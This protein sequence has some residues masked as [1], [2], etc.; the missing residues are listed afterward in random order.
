MYVRVCMYTRVYS[1]KSSPVSGSARIKRLLLF[2]LSETA[3]EI[4]ARVCVCVLRSKTLGIST[5]SRLVRT[6]FRCCHVV[7]ARFLRANFKQSHVASRRSTRP[8]RAEFNRK[9]ASLIASRHVLSAT[10]SRTGLSQ[11]G[12]PYLHG[13]F[14]LR[15]SVTN[16][17][18]RPGEHEIQTRNSPLSVFHFSPDS[19]FESLTKLSNNKL[20][21]YLQLVSIEY[22][23]L[24]AEDEIERKAK[25]IFHLLKYHTEDE[26]GR[27][28]KRIF[29]QFKFNA[30]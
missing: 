23:F 9:M 16:K 11:V 18:P 20:K 7:E 26:I 27:K 1:R 6:I 24:D 21:S 28:A 3:D 17:S 30:V 4:N 2:A 29:D 10:E 8:P 12:P 5:T 25:R 19:D 15:S 13:V 14:A 22:D